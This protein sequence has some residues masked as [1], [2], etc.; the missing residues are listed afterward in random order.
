[1]GSGHRWQAVLLTAPQRGSLGPRLLP[2]HRQTSVYAPES[3]LD[4]QPARDV[5]LRWAA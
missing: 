5:K 4:P 2:K 3:L 1:M